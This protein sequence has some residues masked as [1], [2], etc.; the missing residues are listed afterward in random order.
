[1]EIHIKSRDR[2]A[3]WAQKKHQINHKIICAYLICMEKD[4]IATIE[5]M[6][7]LCSQVNSDLYVRTFNTNYANMKTESA[8]SHGK[9]FED[10][11]HNVWLWEAIEAD[12]MS[13]KNIFLEGKIW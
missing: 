7:R 8:H 3:G 5:S 10:D 9:V 13:R 11:G 12:V 2:M 6:R 4:G 1:M